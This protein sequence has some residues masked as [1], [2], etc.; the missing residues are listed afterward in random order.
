MIKFPDRPGTGV[1]TVF[2]AHSKLLFVFVFIFMTRE[3]ILRCIFVTVCFVT[4]LTR[5][6]DMP[7]GE[8]KAGP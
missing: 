5:R 6:C 7:S 4:I 3:A 8:G 1:V 2:A